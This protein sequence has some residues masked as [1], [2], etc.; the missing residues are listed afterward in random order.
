MRWI[1]EASIDWQWK[2]LFGSLECVCDIDR[3]LQSSVLQLDDI[4]IQDDLRVRYISNRP[5][6]A[7]L[8]RYDHVV[9]Q[10]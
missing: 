6:E 7:R 4:P 2:V 1:A 10:L 5:R 8:Y 3:H 9:R